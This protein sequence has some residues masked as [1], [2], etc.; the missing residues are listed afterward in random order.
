[1]PYTK[2]QIKN[3]PNISD[4][5]HL[6]EAEEQ[7]LYQ[8]YNVAY[9]TEG[10]TFAETTGR[11][12]SSGYAGR[13]TKT[14]TNEQTAAGYDTD[15]AGTDAAMTRSEEQLNVGTERV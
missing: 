2:D 10:S 13:D 12:Q 9:S 14:T 4:S 1:V 15:G 11:A 6:S 3:A 5:G 7:D 8:H